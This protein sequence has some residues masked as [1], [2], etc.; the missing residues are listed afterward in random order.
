MRKKSNKTKSKSVICPY[1]GVQAIL[2]PNSYL[3]GN[4]VAEHLY[5]CT[6]YP[7]CDSYV[8]AHKS[9]LATMGSPANA[10]LR[11][12]RHE[13]HEVFD[14]LWK[15][16]IFTRNGAYMWL[17]DTFFLKGKDAHIGS[18]GIERCERLIKAATVIL[19]N[20]RECQRRAI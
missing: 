4:S 10:E 9:N 7:E 13:A 8:S 2:R 18:F 17:A 15:T 20:R 12:K 6:R 16:G 19:N 3:R 5:V 11:R 1:C 14:Q